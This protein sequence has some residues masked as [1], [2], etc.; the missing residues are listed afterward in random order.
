MA[1]KWGKL[2]LPRTNPFLVKQ[3]SIQFLQELGIFQ[4]TAV[5]Q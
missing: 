5:F 3:F 2:A 4:A 1:E